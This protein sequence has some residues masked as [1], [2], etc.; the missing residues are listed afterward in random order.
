MLQRILSLVFWVFL[1][2]TSILLYPVA[3]LIW[4]ITSPFDRRKVL[5]HK[6][7]CFWASLY[8]WLNPAWPV[9]IEG[10]ERIRRGEAYVMVANHLSFLDIL[11]LFRLFS[12]FKWVSKI[13]NFR[14]PFVGWNM[15][16]NRY[17]KLNRGDRE[18]VTEMM[19]KCEETLGEG[20]SIMM[21]PEGTRSPTG[22]LRE[23][24]P[25]AFELAVKSRRP[26]LPIAIEG[27]AHALPKRGFVLRG[28]HPIRITILKEIPAE[29]FEH[30]SA[31]Q[32]GAHT[33]ELI[34][35]HL[36]RSLSA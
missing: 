8:S 24:K 5:L 26:I 11:V 12:H 13:E 15:S 9:T 23:F 14:V 18:S 19:K 31:E 6:F 3:L 2:L 35:K 25:G 7:T 32:L 4:A 17:I 33:R 36:A 34:A 22:Q 10:R 30:G 28:R 29:S 27:T 1:T 16:L 20:N 21:F